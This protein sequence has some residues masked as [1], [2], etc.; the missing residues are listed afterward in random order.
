[1]PNYTELAS[2]AGDTVLGAIETAQGVAIS[3][4]SSVT[5]TLGSVVPAVP[6]VKLPV[7][8]P[9][10]TEVAELGFSFAKRI[11]ESQERTTMGIIGALKP[12]TAK[13]ATNGTAAK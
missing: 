1:M 9:T 5:S 4:I 11:V 7:T 2:V 13:V 12:L 3:T 10:P 8:L 6:A